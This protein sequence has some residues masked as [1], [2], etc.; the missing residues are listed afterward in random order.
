M[1]AVEQLAIRD[2]AARRRAVAVL[3][4]IRKCKGRAAAVSMRTIAEQTEIRERDIQA[5]VKALVEERHFPIGT[6]TKKPFGYFWIVTDE[7]RRTVRNQFIRR[8]AST[9]AHA[10]AFDNEQLVA[11][12][13]GQLELALQEEETKP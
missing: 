2:S 13:V 5:I 7:E 10:R 8:G 11:P 9:L 6:S 3:A 12:I 4:A 1:T